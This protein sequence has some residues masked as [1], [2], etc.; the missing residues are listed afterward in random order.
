MTGVKLA[1]HCKAQVGSG[2]VWG[3]LGYL[4]NQSRLDQLKKIYPAHYTAAYQAKAKALFGKKVYDCVGLVKHFL[5]GNEGDGVLRKYGTNDI[6]DT[7][8]NGMLKLCVAKGEISTM[9]ELPGLF[10]HMDGHCG[11]YIGGGK[12]VEARGIDYGVVETVLAG[13]GWKSWGK[14]PGV[15]YAAPVEYIHIETY[16]LSQYTVRPVRARL[17]ASDAMGKVTAWAAANYASDATLEGA[18]NASLADGVRPIGTIIE[19]GVI[20]ANGGNGYGFGV[21]SSGAVQFDRVWRDDGLQV[22]WKDMITGYPGLIYRGDKLPIDTTVALFKD[23]HPRQGVALL[24]DDILFVTVDGRRPGMPGMTMTEY[25]DYL[26]GL[27][28]TEAIA[29]D[30]GGSAIQLRDRTQSGKFEIVNAPLEHRMVYNVL[31]AWRKPAVPDVGKP[32]S[33]SITWAE[34]ADRLRAEGVTGIAL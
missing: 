2:Y 31:G 26:H 24:G 5:W 19:D 13:R 23:R 30:G 29:L 9:P 4:F 28:C 12:V 21:D 20:V 8:A 14:L 33:K 32:I 7:T 15:D 18:V 6:P 16:P 3:G 11:V 1:E 17:R 27:G 22:A 25:R 10:V 34:L